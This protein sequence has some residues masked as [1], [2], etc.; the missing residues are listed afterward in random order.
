[1][2][3]PGMRFMRMPIFVWT[4]LF[5]N[6]LMV[7]AFPV[8][9]VA[10]A[11]AALDRY[12]GMHFF[13]STQGG[14]L[15]MYVN[16][17]WIWGHPEVYIL[18]LPAFGVFSEV[19]ATFSA[20]RLFGYRS[21]VYATAAIT[22]LS[23][24]VWVHH[25]FT[26]GAG[27]SV[28]LAFGIATMLI[29]IP[30]GVKVFNWLFTMYRGRVRFTTSMYWTIGFL[31]TFVISGMTGVMMAVP[32]ADFVLHNSLFLVAHFHNV[33]IPGALFGF[34]AGYT[35][36]FPKAMGFPLDEKWGKRAFWFW[37]IGFYLAFAPLYTL[38]FMGMPRRMEHYDNLAWQPYLIVAAVGA[39]VILA[40]ILC[41]ITQLAVSFRQRRATR[42][43]TGDP[44][45]G[46]TL[47]WATSSPPAPY[48][49]AKIPVVQDIDAF[50]DM[51]ER[52][53]ARPLPVHYDDNCM[54]KNTASGRRSD[55]DGGHSLP[56]RLQGAGL[57]RPIAAGA[58]EHVLPLPGHRLGRRFHHRLSIGEHLN[59]SGTDRGHRG[60]P[61]KSQILCRGIPSVDRLQYRGV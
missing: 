12:L 51:K 15:M 19:V 34:F 18:I 53:V 28:N 42:D 4:T 8:L 44:W 49:F 54:P 6:V 2:R 11:L 39:A 60:G 46:R 23:F 26:M 17:F 30:T 3:A 32:P 57:G 55:L 45:D 47:E 10:L 56:G 13:T 9:T 31:T 22:L 14:N 59:E 29:A 35:Y 58:S 40:G 24:G 41:Q 5:T 21:L 33:L 48:N 16:L 37:L 27:P 20:K 36:W 1:M 61:R 52:G 43:L 25:F 7:L 38:G 50:A